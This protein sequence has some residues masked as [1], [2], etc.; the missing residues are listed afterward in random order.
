[1]AGFDCVTPTTVAPSTVAPSETTNAPTTEVPAA[2]W[3]AQK[4]QAETV[5][6]DET[7][8]Y[9]AIFSASA[10]N[11]DG[12]VYLVSSS[13]YSD[14][15]GG[16]FGVLG[17]CGTLVENWF[18][19]SGA[20]TSY[21]S[22]VASASDL[23]PNRATYVAGFDCLALITVAP[24]TVAPS[25]T[26]DAPTA[27]V[28]TEAWNAQKLQEETVVGDETKCY[29]AIFSASACNS[30]GG[31]YLVSS[32]W[33]S[34]HPGGNFGVLG[35]CGR[36]VENWLAKSGSHTAYATGLASASDLSDQATYV[37]DFECVPTDAPTTVTTVDTQTKFVQATVLM[38]VDDA[39]NF[40]ASAFIAGF[41]G[42]A[43]IRETTFAVTS[44]VNMLLDG[45]PIDEAQAREIASVAFGTALS[46]LTVSVEGRRLDGFFSRRLA[47]GDVTIALTTDDAKKARTVSQRINATG[48]NAAAK[49]VTGQDLGIAVVSAPETTVSVVMAVEARGSDADL[50]VA[51][52]QLKDRLNNDLSRIVAEA[53]AYEPRVT[54]EP[55]LV[56]VTTPS[57]T[58]TSTSLSE[59]SDVG[60]DEQ[61]KNGGSKFVVVALPI[62]LGVLGCCCCGLACCWYR[63]SS[64][65]AW[66]AAS[67]TA[68]A[69]SSQHGP[70]LLLQEATDKA[71]SKLPEQSP[72][73]AESPSPDNEMRLPDNEMRL[74]SDNVEMGP[75]VGSQTSDNEIMASWRAGAGAVREDAASRYDNVEMEPAVTT[76]PVS[77][78]ASFQERARTCST[79]PPAALPPTPST[80]LGAR[81]THQDG[82]EENKA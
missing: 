80:R 40:S 47:Q 38:K 14:H 69:T 36:L 71:A 61:Q 3:N 57:P 74:D 16:N 75:P 51:Q 56:E 62:V 78:F 26:T 5:I 64:G 31:V 34:D 59:P 67:P 6:G 15:T 79:V 49:R 17:T 20:H 9:V 29:V 68:T 2:A 37:A 72:H 44:I 70:T 42:S 21:A 77:A 32:S 13:W 45:F 10:C 22:A 76:K 43:Q 81:W 30:D 19:K 63:R 82:V 54:E 35:T 41:G 39:T 73:D 66:C 52:N 11:S 58:G 60:G 7:K 48:L 27:G 55:A 28:P 25:T 4:L 8:C 23:L 65:T 33:Y 18:A 46:T 53:G 1:V 50:V 12:G 24:S